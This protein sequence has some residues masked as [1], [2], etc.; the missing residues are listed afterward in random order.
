MLMAIDRL[1]NSAIF[2]QPNVFAKFQEMEAATVTHSSM[3][4]DRIL[5]N[6]VVIVLGDRPQETIVM[7]KGSVLIKSRESLLITPGLRKSSR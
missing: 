3:K 2:S 1:F 7:G 6:N 5:N 4:I